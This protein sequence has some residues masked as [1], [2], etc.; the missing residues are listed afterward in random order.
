MNKSS[1]II[2]LKMHVTENVCFIKL[3]EVDENDYLKGVATP[4][5]TSETF[6]KKKTTKKKL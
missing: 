4:T 1:N 3:L 5:L 2:E 6:F